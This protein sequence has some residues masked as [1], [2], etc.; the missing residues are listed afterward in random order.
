M[1]I[2]VRDIYNDLIKPFQNFRLVVVFYSVK[3]KLLISDTTLRSFVPPQVRKITP[4]LRQICGCEICV[5]PKDI[6]FY[7][8]KFRTRP[9]TYLQH[10]YVG[11]H[12]RFFLFST[13]STAHYKD[14]VFP[15]IEYLNATIKYAAHCITCLPIKPDNII[16]IECDS[17]YLNEFMSTISL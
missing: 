1:V 7:L 12:T 15:D 14:I 11:R 9:V 8:N 10:N 13:I 16:H 6:H 3:Q 5:I 17:I 4:E 2:S